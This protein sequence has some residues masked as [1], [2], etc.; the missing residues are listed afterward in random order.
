MVLD[1]DSEGRVF[2][3]SQLTDYICRNE[4]LAGHNIFDYFVDTYEK[5]ITA[6]DRRDQT[7]ERASSPA[8]TNLGR[9]PHERYSYLPNHPKHK[10]M[11]R[12]ER[13]IGHNNLPNF[14][15]RFFPRRDDLESHSFYC[16]SM[17]LLLKPWRDIR[18]DLK[19]SQQ[20][21]EEAFEEFMSAAPLKYKNILS[22]IQYFH[23]CESS[24]KEQRTDGGASVPYEGP[25]TLSSDDDM[26]FSH[27]HYPP[28]HT[29]RGH[30]FF[31]L[32]EGI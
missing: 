26:I 8:S 7:Q 22:G 20:S 23:E 15:G 16:A 21:W 25:T 12:I 2:P 3:K 4:T 1:V 6:R 29:T 32:G 27:S 9:P 28:Q 31:T 18:T 5:P 13:M 10:S 14:I 19:T 24:A 17:L 30:D 11:Q